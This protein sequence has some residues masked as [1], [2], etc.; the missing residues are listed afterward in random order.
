MAILHTGGTRLEPHAPSI[1]LNKPFLI[2]LAV[3]FIVAMHFFMQNPGGS[4]LALSFNATTWTALSVTLSIGLYQLAT[5]QSLMY[6]KLTIGLLV[7]CLLMTV[8]T[9]YG[10]AT[11]S[12]ALG[13]LIGL[14]TGFLL[15]VLLQQFRFSNKHKQRLLWFIVIAVFIQSVFGFYQYLLLEPNNMFGYDALRNR[16]YGIFQQPNVM[17][18]FLATGL[19]ISAYLLARQTNK[20]SRLSE[21]SFLC[22]IPLLTAPLLII[23]ASRTGWLGAV[24]SLCFVLPYLYKYSTRKRFFSWV[25]C[26]LIGVG[27]GFFATHSQ[28]TDALLSSKADLESPRKY[29]FPQ[30]LDMVIEKPFTGYGYGNFEAEY[31]LYTARQ[32]QLNPSYK[33]GLPAMDHPHN[34]LLFWGVEGGLIPLLA[35]VLAASLVLARIYYA[36]KGIRLAMFALFVPIVVHS[37]LE[38]PFYHSA[39]HWITF[40][41]LLF[42]VD[43]RVAS[44]KRL[45]FGQLTKSFLRV[46][47]II[48]PLITS[49]YMFSA[50]HT[51][52]VL[53]LFERSSPKQP[54]ILDR[55]TNP[56]VWKDRF[57]WDI[58]STYL[59]IGLH[60]QEPELIKPYIQWSLDMIQSKPRPA[61][62][63]NLILAYQGLGDSSRAEQIRAEAQYLFPDKDFT[64]IQYRPKSSAET[65]LTEASIPSE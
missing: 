25:I 28:G 58:Y 41:I 4:G 10:N 55:V 47:C 50:L 48:A 65:A 18:S 11:T 54:E 17:A 53:T 61:F 35:I 21:T 45:H 57:D 44:Y 24:I 62:Y 63:S 43:Q 8:P 34:E 26:C 9:F 46:M 30:A 29:T 56:V 31:I 6:S 13:R 19:V 27:L 2:S 42:W 39:V 32:H 14:W 7:C 3:V 52:Y 51:N 64:A 49:F 12:A 5:N 22:L 38:Y 36:K 20:Y 33:P 23:I 37:Q 15:F 59:N 16:P 60:T 1:P 40:M